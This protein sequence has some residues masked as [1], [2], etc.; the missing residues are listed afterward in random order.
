MD[1]FSAA[2]SRAKWMEFVGRE[3]ICCNLLCG[4]TSWLVSNLWCRKGL[5]PVLCAEE[6]LVAPGIKKNIHQFGLFSSQDWRFSKFY[7][8]LKNK[9]KAVF[10]IQ[11]PGR[12]TPSET[13]DFLDFKRVR[14]CI[15]VKGHK[16]PGC[17]LHRGN[18]SLDVG[19]R[20]EGAFHRS[21]S[22][23]SGQP[24]CFS[25]LKQLSQVCIHA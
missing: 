18:N 15:V 23:W 17:I 7:L 1:N 12:R 19:S 22:K 14:G 16:T 8:P 3:L 11:S 24:E 4:P 10:C 9:V 2:G 5:W 6:F 25:L 21:V 20:Y 13:Y